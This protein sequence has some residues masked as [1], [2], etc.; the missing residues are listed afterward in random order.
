MSGYELTMQSGCKNS[1]FTCV[2]ADIFDAM[3]VVKSLGL[4]L[5]VNS[6]HWAQGITSRSV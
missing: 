2:S 6:A 5:R 1:I 3:C 4:G